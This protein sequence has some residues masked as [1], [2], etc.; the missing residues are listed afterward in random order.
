MALCFIHKELDQERAFNKEN[1]N[2]LIMPNTQEAFDEL[3]P[4]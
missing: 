1:T 3:E 4:L 2:V